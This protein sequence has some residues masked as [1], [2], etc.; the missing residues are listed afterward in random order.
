MESPGLVRRFLFVM[1][2]AETEERIPERVRNHVPLILKTLTDLS[3][4]GSRPQVA[5]T[6]KDGTVVG[7]A[8]KS[9]E[10]PAQIMREIRAHDKGDPSPTRLRDQI[11]ILELGNTFRIENAERLEGWLN[12]R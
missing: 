7:I 1:K 10:R 8:F 2:F 11:L 6:A 5:F 3:A 12:N 4:M 9:E